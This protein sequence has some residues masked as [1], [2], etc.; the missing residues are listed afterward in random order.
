MPIL[1]QFTE[2]ITNHPVFSSLDQR[3]LAAVMT[4]AMKRTLD[5]GEFLVH[6]DVLW[7]YLFIVAEGE[8]HAVKE[9][10]EGRVLIATSIQQGEIFWGLGFFIENATMPVALQA[11]QRSALLTWE[12]SDLMP[13]FKNNGAMSW[14]IC[15]MMI[16]R[17]Q[18]ASGIVEEL[19]FQPVVS[20]LAG[21]LLDVFGDAE[22]EFVSRELTLDDMAA[23][24]GTTREVVCRH[25][26]RF[27]ER[28]AIEIR[29]TELKL[30]DRALLKDHASNV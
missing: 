3:D 18:V 7:P 10:Q 11:N 9:S 23:H 25:L 13:I 6:Q 28:G 26:Y 15:Q 4:S 12:R 19:A 1:D 14:S 27:A 17:M 21:L 5:E 24:I 30:Q 29:R 8:I 22:G 16:R 20:R 2:A